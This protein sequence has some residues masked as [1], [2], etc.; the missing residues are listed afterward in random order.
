MQK[1]WKERE[2]L[3]DHNWHGCSYCLL[4]KPAIPSETKYGQTY[5]LV[6]HPLSEYLSSLLV[7]QQMY[8]LFIS[9][10]NLWDW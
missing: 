7:E 3:G 1:M 4:T 6:L 5:Y 2:I 10:M 9:T 8:V